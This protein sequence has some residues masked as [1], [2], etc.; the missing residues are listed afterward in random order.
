MGLGWLGGFLA[1]ERISKPSQLTSS[2]KRGVN[3]FSAIRGSYCLDSIQG[4]HLHHRWRAVVQDTVVL[5][6]ALYLLCSHLQPA[7]RQAQ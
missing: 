6:P 4:A 7:V 2:R 5:I 3:A 1:L